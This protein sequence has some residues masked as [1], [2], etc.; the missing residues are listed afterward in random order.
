MA[1]SPGYD[2]DIF[3][4]YAHNDNYGFG[5]QPGWVDVFE[6]WLFLAPR[7]AGRPEQP[8]FPPLINIDILD[9]SRSDQIDPHITAR[10][11]AAGVGQ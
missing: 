11:L 1:Q 8:P 5:G 2:P 9:N 10:L 3:I 4:S 7:S 6:D